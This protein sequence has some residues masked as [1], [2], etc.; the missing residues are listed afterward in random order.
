MINPHSRGDVIRRLGAVIDLIKE[1]ESRSAEM[2]CRSDG[3][4]ERELQTCKFLFDVG[5]VIAGVERSIRVK[6]YF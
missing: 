1:G 4:S 5:F 2:E 6:G 3:G